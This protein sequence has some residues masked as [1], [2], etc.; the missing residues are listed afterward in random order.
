[1]LTTFQLITLD[2]WEDVYNKVI[3]TGGPLQVV[4]F[5]IVV[6]FGS[7]YLINLMLAVVAMS[8]EEEAENTEEE[9]TKDLMDHRDDSTFSFDPEKLTHARP[10]EKKKPKNRRVI[11]MRG[12]GILTDKFSKRKKKKEEKEGKAGEPLVRRHHQG[13]CGAPNPPRLGGSQLGG[14]EGLQSLSRPASLVITP[15]P[16]PLPRPTRPTL[17]P[18]GAA[19]AWPPR[20]KVGRVG[21]RRV[22]LAL[23]PPPAADRH[24]HS[25]QQQQQAATSP[26]PGQ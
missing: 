12:A 24:C 21:L 9:K 20:E 7:F 3:A 18:W 5:A 6:F 17:R 1:M 4:F 14:S 22:T 26:P 2:F 16:C 23:P 15:P 19:K 11:V 8:Y 13:T 25:R 10:L